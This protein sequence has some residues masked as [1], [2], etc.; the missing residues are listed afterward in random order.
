MIILANTQKQKEIVIIKALK[1]SSRI[2]F[3]ST[4]TF[5]NNQ[6]K[7]VQNKTAK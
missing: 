3:V 5:P 2:L 4:Y 7:Q 1:L 6:K